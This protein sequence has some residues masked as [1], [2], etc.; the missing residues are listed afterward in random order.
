MMRTLHR[1]ATPAA[2]AI[3]LVVP[4]VGGGAIAGNAYREK[5][6]P[7]AISGS[8]LTV[9]PPR[10]WNKLAVSPGRKT[11]TWT[12]D[13][14]DLNDVT[15]FA[16]IEPGQPLFREVSKSRKPLP[17]F[18]ATTLLVEVPELVE[19]SYRAA[20]D[21]VDF[22]VTG[23]AGDRFLGHE[24]IRFTFAYVDDDALT[25][26]GEGRATLVDGALYMIVFAAPRLAYYD[27]TLGDF[28]A[29]AD[30]ARLN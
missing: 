23:T 30:T 2:L 29:L 15:F 8:S 1:R 10:D 13:G 3:L 16:G 5:G 28:R 9:T 19:G 17:R 7:A 25:R 6:K 21:V 27:R 22:T 18:T 26:R 20:K 12:L 24:G 11:E 14:E 4:V